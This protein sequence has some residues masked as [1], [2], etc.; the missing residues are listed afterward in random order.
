MYLPTFWKLQ[1]E[2]S[3][4]RFGRMAGWGLPAVCM[5]KYYQRFESLSVVIKL[6]LIASHN[7]LRQSQT[8]PCQKTQS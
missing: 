3:V 1:M 7:A 6:A 2:A 5:S 4:Y 8:L